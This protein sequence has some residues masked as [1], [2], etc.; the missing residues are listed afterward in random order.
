MANVLNFGIQFPFGESSEGKYLKLTKSVSEEIKSSLIH[1]LLTRKGSRYFL[2]SFGTKLY[3]YIFE[4]MDENTFTKIR[5]EVSEAVKE[6]MP[7]ISIDNIEV[8]P[9]S[10]TDE[11]PSKVITG[12]DERLYRTASDGTEEYTAKLKISYR[13][14]NGEFG[15]KDFV[16]INL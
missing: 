8:T 11:A 15:T 7:Q 9:Y 5:N 4:P 2:P 6:F 10:E 13:T 1:L 12:K 14:M 16:V 3:D